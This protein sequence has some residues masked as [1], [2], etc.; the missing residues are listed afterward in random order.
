[1]KTPL[2]LFFTFADAEQLLKA[3]S[4]P[5][6]DRYSAELLR[7]Q[8]LGLPPLVSWSVLSVAVGVSP[9]FITSILKNKSKY[10]R[11][12]PI[13]KGKGKK[14]RIIEAPK[15]SLKIIQ[16][17]FAYHI[18][19]NDNIALSENAYAFILVKM[20][21]MMPQVCIVA[22]NG[23]CLLI[24]GIFSIRSHRKQWH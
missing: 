23:S 19:L 20:E 17:W 11:V 18:S 21:Y 10:Y 4:K 15:V 14:K 8:Q 3:L 24:L 12:F 5:L 22:Q 1:M 16:S 7:L 9:Q 13:A 6:R 2:P